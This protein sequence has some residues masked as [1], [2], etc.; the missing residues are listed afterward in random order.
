[1]A[2]Q[3]HRRLR[4]IIDRYKYGYDRNSNR[5]WK[6]NVVGTAAVTAGLDEFYVY[7]PLNRLTEMQRG[8]L[9][10]T[11]TGI[12]GTPSV[13]QDWTL[14]L[15]GNWSNFITKASGTTNLDQTRTANTVNEITNIT[16]STGPTWVT[17]TYDAAGNTTTMPQPADL[18]SSF[19]AVYDAWNR[20]ASILAGTTPVGKYQY[21]G[22]NFRVV[23]HTY[24]AGMLNQTRDVYCTA[25]WRNI[26]ERVSGTTEDQ[27]VWGIRYIDEL[28]CR[29]DPADG[30]LYATQ[31]ANFNL[32][33]IV[34]SSTSGSVVE[35]YLF[36]PY[37][38]RAVMNSSWAVR[39]AT[40]YSWNTGHQGLMIDL[41]SRLIDNRKRPLHSLLA[42]FGGR[43]PRGYRS[44]QNLYEYADSNPASRID[45]MGLEAAAVA[46]AEEV[47][48]S[49]CK[50]DVAEE[51]GG[52][53]PEDPFADAVVLVTSIGGVIVAGA[54]IVGLNSPSNV[55]RPTP[56][57]AWINQHRRCV[58][59]P[60]PPKCPAPQSP[61]K[62]SRRRSDLQDCL[63]AANGG[64]DA[65]WVF[66][67]SI[68]STTD[69]ERCRRLAGESD[70][71]QERINWC[72]WFYG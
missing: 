43:D 34:A 46:E 26:E 37:G 13:E 49:T 31:D 22:R 53:G 50:A 69:R 4:R 25:N 12:T 17:P 41:E 65:W 15:T 32:T 28:V 48:K 23:T 42:Q 39:T 54:I 30:R 57:E 5:L 59:Q 47:L 40:G 19:T 51:I 18:T 11:Q 10:G 35:R 33:S 66:C 62:P 2:E 21:D 72:N 63:E 36:T 64:S 20:M 55:H 14:D 6:N 38:D 16:A 68:P 61:V 60:Q 7:D 52:G 45:P 1:M 9:N 70:R 24:V 71:K 58:P 27:Y 56:R 44:G 3:H 29:D 67:D 8:V